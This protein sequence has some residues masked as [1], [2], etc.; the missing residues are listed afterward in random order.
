MGIAQ[1]R[2]VIS[3]QSQITARAQSTLKLFQSSQCAC[4]VLYIFGRQ[5]IQPNRGLDRR[6]LTADETNRGERVFL[7]VWFVVS[8]TLF[9]TYGPQS[10]T[11]SL[12][13]L[14]YI[15]QGSSHL[16]SFVVT[17]AACQMCGGPPV[18]RDAPSLTAQKS[19]KTCQLP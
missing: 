14:S 19:A 16:A 15:R 12:Q 10:I 13:Q 8:S 7:F 9:Q 4:F 17:K 2:K 18:V 11:P 5:R 6:Y 3:E 1:D